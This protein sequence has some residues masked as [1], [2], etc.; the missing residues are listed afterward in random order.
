[1]GPSAGRQPPGPL[2]DA[3]NR[4]FSSFDQF[5]TQFSSTA[6]GIFGSGWAWLTVDPSGAI[7]LESTTNQDNPLMSGRIPFFGI[8]V[9]E[10]AYYLNYYNRSADYI[11]HWWNVINWANVARR[12]EAALK[13]EIL[14]IV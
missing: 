11:R 13:G 5:K 9:W 4:T 1:M 12:D 6:A 2:A 10:R 14:Y 7:S 3:I 8:T